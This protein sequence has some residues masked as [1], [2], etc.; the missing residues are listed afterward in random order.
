MEEVDNV[1]DKERN[2]THQYVSEGIIQDGKRQRDALDDPRREIDER[3]DAEQG[4]GITPARNDANEC[5]EIVSIHI[6]RQAVHRLIGFVVHQTL[7]PQFT[8]LVFVHRLYDF[9]AEW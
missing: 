9:H 8:F 2:H 3:H 7:T 5:I 4:N 6:A 1:A